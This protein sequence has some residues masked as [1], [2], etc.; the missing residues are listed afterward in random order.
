MGEPTRCGR[1]SSGV[2][3]RVKYG[4]GEGFTWTLRTSGYLRIRGRHSGLFASRKR[5]RKTDFRTPFGP[6]GSSAVLI[7]SNKSQRHATFWS[8][9]FWVFVGK[10]FQ[11]RLKVLCISVFVHLFYILIN[12]YIWI[13]QLNQTNLLYNFDEKMIKIVVLKFIYFT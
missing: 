4:A 6:E 2:I 1:D 9:S 3:Q 5:G 7:G 13:M 10:L 8:S 11:Q 12:L